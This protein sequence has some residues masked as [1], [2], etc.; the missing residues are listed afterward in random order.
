MISLCRALTNAS[1]ARARHRITD[2][3]LAFGGFIPGKDKNQNGSAAQA[4]TQDLGA[5]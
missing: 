2:F 3:L 4:D 1:P 5:G